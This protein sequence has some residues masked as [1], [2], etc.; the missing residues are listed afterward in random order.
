MTIEVPK[1]LKNR[2]KHKGLPIPYIAMITDEGVADFRITDEEKRWDVMINQ[3][4]QLCAEPLGKYFF[5]TG[6]VEAAK[7]NL[8]FEP[9]AHL[10]CLLYAMQV[11]PFI[12]GRT[13]HVDPD[14]IAAK[15]KGTTI[16]VIKEILPGR[17]P[18]WVIKKADDYRYAKVITTGQV[19]IQPHVIFETKPICPEKMSPQD[20]EDVKDILLEDWK[21]GLLP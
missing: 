6:G 11:C 10:D 1:R 5:F 20:W 18:L 19:L 4:C 21:E 15:H 13:D 17:N 14:K 9:A 2:P 7:A 12:V 16:H 3:K 8:Y